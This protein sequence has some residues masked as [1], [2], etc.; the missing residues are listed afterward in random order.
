[1][2]Q[3]VPVINNKGGVGKTTTTVNVA[4]GLAR[5]GRNVLL[6]DLDSQGSASVSIGVSNDN[7]TP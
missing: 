7:L 6:V 1:M 3:I 2:L 4:A 5:K